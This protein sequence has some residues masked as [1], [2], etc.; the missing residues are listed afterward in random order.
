MDNLTLI[1]HIFN[2]EYLLPFWLEHHS[3]IFKNGI[4]IDYLSTDNSVNII[5]KYCPHWKIINTS[6]VIKGKSF[7]DTTGLLIDHEVIEIEKTIQG[8]K[9]CLN[10]TEFLFINDNI[11][12]NEEKQ[13]YK[14]EQLRGFSN[15]DYFYPKNNKELFNNIVSFY[16]DRGV[17]HL[18]N[19]EYLDYYPG[20]H[21]L[22]H[23]NYNQTLS[24]DMIIIYL[25]TYNINK[26][27][28]KRRLQ[29]QYNVPSFLPLNHY[30]FPSEQHAI[31]S[32]YELKKKSF[33][34]D[35]DHVVYKIINCVL[36]KPSELNVICN[37]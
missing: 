12:L 24:N 10:V 35:K 20:R 34:L 2:E 14:I 15:D 26:Y 32:Y 8:Y 6:N 19:Y 33:I 3:K 13:V 23:N 18:H 36:N 4:I 31:D 16:N 29:I 37:M 11:K 28:M 7:F 5:K 25:S 30:E 1:A 22:R 17:R 27:F 9:I 21:W